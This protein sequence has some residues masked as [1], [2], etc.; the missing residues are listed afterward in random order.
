MHQ[1][2]T[3]TIGDDGVETLASGSP[4]DGS[5]VKFTIEPEY[6]AELEMLP[7]KGGVFPI[8]NLSLVRTANTSLQRYRVVKQIGEDHAGYPDVGT[9]ADADLILGVT[10]ET[11]GVGKSLSIRLVGE[12]E[13]LN[14][15]WSP[16]AL[17]CG[18]NGELTQVPPSGAWQRQ[19][20][21]ALSPTKILVSMRPTGATARTILNGEGPPT[22]PV[23]DVGDY[24]VDTLNH[25]FYGPKIVPGW[26]PFVPLVGPVGPVGPLGPMGPAAPLRM[27]IYV[28]DR[29][30][31]LESVMRYIVLDSLSIDPSKTKASAEIA[32]ESDCTFFLLR[33]NSSFLDIR[34]TA[35]SSVATM[36]YH[37][38][39]VM[40]ND[41]LLLVAPQNTDPELSHISFVFSWFVS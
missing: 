20:G 29:P 16:G 11:A 7:V 13:D 36:V 31:P 19:I 22:L 34:F 41:I 35:G 28:G 5:A 40:P 8:T 25:R 9:M 30:G 17:Y 39:V 10:V 38:S 14:W 12:I 21:A 23:G 18:F 27:S 15:N 4:A 24:Y 32:T 2:L 3:L 26:G 1:D 37:D 6:L 33:N